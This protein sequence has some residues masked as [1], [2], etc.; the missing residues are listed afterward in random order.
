MVR[1]VIL[2]LLFPLT[3]AWTTSLETLIEISIA[4]ELELKD[5]AILL[6]NSEEHSENVMRLL[7]LSRQNETKLSAS[8]LRTKAS[9]ELLSKQQERDQRLLSRQVTN[10]LE[11]KSSHD[12]LRKGF[13]SYREAAE[14]K[15]RNLTGTSIALGVIAGGLA[16]WH[17]VRWVRDLL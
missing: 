16:I 12:L 3:S 10:Y 9:L 17:L 6:A 11:L 5:T 13:G 14:I 15:I 1:V 7:E 2:F 8:L 4:L